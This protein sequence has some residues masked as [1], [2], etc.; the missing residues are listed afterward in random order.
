M[1]KIRILG[2]SEM[3][4]CE[5]H[6]AIFATG[7]NITFKGD[8]VRRG[9][10]CDLETLNERPEL[11]AFKQDTLKRSAADRSA[12]VAAALTSADCLQCRAHPDRE[13]PHPHQAR[14]QAA[15]KATTHTPI[16]FYA[17]TDPV[18]VKLVDL[19]PRPGGRLTGVHTRVTD[20]TGKRVEL[21]REIVANLRR[22][23]TY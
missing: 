1:I 19:I 13:D 16:V 7:N 23:V 2:R 18:V 10:V 14:D 20:V 11:R 9:L 12:Y 21:L 17:G 5:C 4:D 3:P 15:K 8:L 22:V 6:T